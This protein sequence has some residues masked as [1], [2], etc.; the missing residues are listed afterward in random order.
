MPLIE[1]LV[2]NG[3]CR[4]LVTGSHL[5]SEQGATYGKEFPAYIDQVVDKVETGNW[6]KQSERSAV[7]GEALE[8]FLD[9]LASSSFDFAVILGDRIEALLFA[10]ACSISGVRIV[11]LHG[12][13]VTEG[14][15]DELHR[16]AITKLS[17]LHFVIGEHEKLRVVQL[18]EDPQRVFVSGSPREDAIFQRAHLSHEEFVGALGLEVP[19]EFALVSM[20]PAAL[21][22]VPSPVLARDILRELSNLPLFSL[23]TGPNSDLGS[24]DLRSTLKEFCSQNPEKSMYVESLGSVLYLSALALA[25]VAIGNSSSLILEAP[26]V[27]CPTVLVGR[28]QLGRDGW[29]GP[30]V[31]TPEG[32]RSA[33]IRALGTRGQM[34]FRSELS[35][36]VAETIHSLILSNRDVPFAKRFH[37]V[38]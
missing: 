27:G 36:G 4:V 23:V 14:A 9:Y 6:Q 15:L 34:I 24:D 2:Q 17:H 33:V 28:R 5:N 7:L 10:V 19:R 22:D 29:H 25:Q 20:H 26:K 21:D 18:G 16:H 12:G 37:H 38:E 13:E 1:V 31:Q 35:G 11:H 3:S 30:I 32:I 8:K